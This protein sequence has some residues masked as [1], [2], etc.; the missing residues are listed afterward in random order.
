DQIEMFIGEAVRV[1]E[2]KSGLMAMAFFGGSNSSKD[3]RGDTGDFLRD[4]KGMGQ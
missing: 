4:M 1:D 2:I 3:R